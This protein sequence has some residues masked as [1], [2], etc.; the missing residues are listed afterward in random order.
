MKF[1]KTVTHSHSSTS[2]IPCRSVLLGLYHLVQLIHAKRTR[3]K[4]C[5]TFLNAA[6]CSIFVFICNWNNI[7]NGYPF[8]AF[9]WDKCL[10]MIR[11]KCLA[12]WISWTR[13]CTLS[14]KIV[15]NHIFLVFRLRPRDAITSDTPRRPT[16]ALI[17]L[18]SRIIIKTQ[19]NSDAAVT[20]A[21]SVGRDFL[22][23]NFPNRKCRYL[24]ISESLYN[25]TSITG[26]YWF[27]E[28]RSWVD[29][30]SRKKYFG[31]GLN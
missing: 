29:K 15:A 14:M 19:V 12:W 11:T 20:D 27:Y 7:C 4:V 3:F 16:S 13:A 1:P 9:Q 6:D 18:E 28:D 30:I 21:F 17:C 23:V 24:V 10:W 26:N 31:N 5:K 8:H 2:N 22:N 25:L